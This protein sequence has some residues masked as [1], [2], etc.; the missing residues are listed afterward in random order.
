MHLVL[1]GIFSPPKGGSPY[2][3]VTISTAALRRRVPNPQNVYTFVNM[4]GGATAANTRE[5]RR[6]R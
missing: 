1:R 4:A 6:P 2:G 3:D 5:A